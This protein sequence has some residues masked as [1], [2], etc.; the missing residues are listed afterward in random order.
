M[1]FRH[2]VQG[3]STVSAKANSLQLHLRQDRDVSDKTIADGKEPLK[4]KGLPAA[5][6]TFPR[7]APSPA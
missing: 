7:P 2:S 6:S 3:L 4:I 1:R 5:A